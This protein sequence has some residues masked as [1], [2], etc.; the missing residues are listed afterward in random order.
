MDIRPSVLL[1]EDDASVRLGIEQALALADIPVRAFERAEPALERVGAGLKG[2]VVTDVRLPGIDGLACLARVMAVDRDIPVVLI[3]G[4]G[5]VAMAVQAMREGAYDFIEK[6][7][8][9]DRLVE[10]VQRA[11]DRRRLVLEN[12][13]LK[14]QLMARRA[15]RLLGEGAAIRNIRRL[16]GTLAP[17]EV[18]VLIYGETGTGKEVL[19]RAIHAASERHGEFVAINCGALPESV[20]ESEV[21]GHEAGAFTGAIKRRIGKIEHARG[22]TLFLDEIETMPPAL[23]VKLLRVL[24]ERKLERLGSNQTIEVDCRVIAASK[25][26]LKALSDEGRFRSDLYYRLNVVCLELPALR[27]RKEDIPLLATHFL[28]EAAQ[29]YR[30]PVPPLSEQQIDE[31]MAQDWPGNVR[32]LRNAVDRF[33]LG[34]AVSEER[35]GDAAASLAQRMDRFERQL[36]EDAL[37]RCAGSVGAAAERLQMPRKT[38]YDKLQRHRLFPDDY[39]ARDQH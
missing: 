8:K 13:E 20:F 9:S 4:H 14:E 1:I 22:G 10:V 21:F 27:E 36:I 32:E 11:L 5:G 28:F 2:V 31:W 24:Q 23:Q 12:R 19:A 26:D 30:C 15:V 16:V 39:R 37:H 18:D 3:T 33:C 17:T 29:R 35:D 25:A 6:P 38:L 34:V 7:F